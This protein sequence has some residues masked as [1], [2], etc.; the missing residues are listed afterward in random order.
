MEGLAQKQDGASC[1][2]GLMG[3]REALEALARL[4]EREPE[5]ALWGHSLTALFPQWEQVGLM[6]LASQIG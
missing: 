4:G 5:R 3:H 1:P 6:L 2:Q